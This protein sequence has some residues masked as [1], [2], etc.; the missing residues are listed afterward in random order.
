MYI[1][2]RSFLYKFVFVA[3]IITDEEASS[4]VAAGDQAIFNVSGVDV[5]KIRLVC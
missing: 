3:A 2:P 1:Y 5:S 4:W